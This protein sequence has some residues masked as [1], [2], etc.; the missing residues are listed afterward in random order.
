MITSKSLLKVIGVIESAKA[1]HILLFAVMLLLI[2][3]VQNAMLIIMMSKMQALPI[4]PSYDSIVKNLINDVL[5]SFNVQMLDNVN[6]L[7]K[8]V[9]LNSWEKSKEILY[10]FFQKELLGA[11]LLLGTLCT[12]V[13]LW[14]FYPEPLY[15]VLEASY[16]CFRYISDPL[17]NLASGVQTAFGIGF[18]YFYNTTEFVT[19]FS[20]FG[21]KAMF[22]ITRDLGKRSFEVISPLVAFSGNRRDESLAPISIP[23]TND[24]HRDL[25]PQQILGTQDGFNMQRLPSPVDISPFNNNVVDDIASIAPED[26]ESILEFFSNMS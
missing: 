14:I 2:N 16:T 19:K 21:I 18:G 3:I 5:K 26:P 11:G 9:D 17:S 24:F 6:V 4:L 7:D 8:K 1:K 25:I 13:C 10:S 23:R 20:F 12:V 22:A 15:S